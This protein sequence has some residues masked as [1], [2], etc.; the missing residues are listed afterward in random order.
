MAVCKF[1]AA[2]FP[3][4]LLH[5]LAHSF[6]DQSYGLFMYG[7]INTTPQTRELEKEPWHQLQLFAFEAW[8]CLAKNLLAGP[9]LV[10]KTR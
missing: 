9:S 2:C 8:H 7:G 3:E 1:M 5:F 10:L 6:V 4:R